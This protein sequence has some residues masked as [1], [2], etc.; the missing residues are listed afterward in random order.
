MEGQNHARITWK[1]NSKKGLYFSCKK[2]IN[3]NVNVQKRR[4]KMPI[5]SNL[6]QFHRRSGS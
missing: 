5:F 2:T 6:I 3:K 4:A 1:S